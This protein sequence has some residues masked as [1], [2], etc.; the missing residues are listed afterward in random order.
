M[1]GDS[2]PCTC[3]P[4]AY[5][6]PNPLLPVPV[7]FVNKRDFLHVWTPSPLNQALS[8][9][10]G[11]PLDLGVHRAVVWTSAW[12]GDSGKRPAQGLEVALGIFHQ[13]VPGAWVPWTRSR[14]RKET[15]AFGE[16]SHWPQR[17]SSPW[18]G[19][20]GCC[21]LKCRAQGTVFL[22]WVQGFKARTA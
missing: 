14:S 20:T 21:P 5:T 7:R 17:F 22:A 6:F 10:L 13:R 18:K 4:L 1:G 9:P 19:E 12:E 3:Q 2:R 15:Q 11:H 16:R 8:T